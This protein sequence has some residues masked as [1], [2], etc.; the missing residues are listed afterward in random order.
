[1]LCG[2]NG[3]YM[4][5]AKCKQSNSHT[6]LKTLCSCFLL[7]YKLIRSWLNLPTGGYG[8]VICMGDLGGV[9]GGAGSFSQDITPEGHTD[10]HTSSFVFI[11]TS[12]WEKIIIMNDLQ[13][14]ML[15]YNVIYYEKLRKVTKRID[16]KAF[17]WIVK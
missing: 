1:M 10:S 4:Y 9:E 3:M 2:L 8:H 11:L 15:S 7:S 14:P 12:R 6:S 17:T 5:W 13:W 16:K